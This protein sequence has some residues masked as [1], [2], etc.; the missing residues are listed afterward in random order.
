MS[1][2]PEFHRLCTC[3]TQRTDLSK[4]DKFTN[5][6]IGLKRDMSPYWDGAGKSYWV[7]STP[8]WRLWAEIQNISCISTCIIS[9]FTSVTGMAS[10]ISPQKYL[11]PLQAHVCHVQ[12]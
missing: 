11:G 6:P 12:S 1:R 8:E 5:A 9:I 4:A 7:R 3:T 10:S 2:G